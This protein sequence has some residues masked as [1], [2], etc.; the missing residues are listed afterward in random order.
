MRKIALLLASSI[1]LTG[2]APSSSSP[3]AASPESSAEETSEGIQVEEGLLTVEVTL[4]ASFVSLGGEEMTQEKLDAAIAE[5]G[6]LGGTINSDGSVT[7]TMTK[8]KQQELLAESKKSFDESIAEMMAQYPN[9]KSIT[10]TDDFSVI[11]VEISE[12]SLETGFLG[13]GL[14]MSA[15][16]YQIFDGREFAADVVYVDATTG[17][18]ISRTSYPL[19][20]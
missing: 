5:G 9:V 13:L 14:S 1:F 3:D 8:L 15:Y 2:C 20:N 18:E 4:P 6:Y 11:T 10:R 7:Y 17:E 16:F 12:Q 19:E